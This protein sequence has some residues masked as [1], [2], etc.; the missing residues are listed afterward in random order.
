MR[1]SGA[2][3]D[4]SERGEVDGRPAR[5]FSLIELV[6]VL[7][8]IS[9]VAGMAVPMVAVTITRT[10]IDETRNE[11]RAMGP[12]IQSF[13]WDCRRFPP[14][15]DALQHNSAK[16]AGWRG[17]Y[18]NPQV[19]ARANVSHSLAQ[20]A[21]NR[22]YVLTAGDGAAYAPTAATNVITIRSLGPDGIA[23]SDD[24]IVQSVD[25]VFLRRK[26]TIDELNILNGAIQAYNAQ[27]IATAPLP[28]NMA[29]LFEALYVAGLLPRPP[30]K[31]KNKQAEDPLRA[32]AWGSAYRASPADAMPVIR[33]ES[34]NVSGV[35][36][37]G[38]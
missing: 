34:P 31:N 8:I 36:P 11:L 18:L 38:G 21:W 23:N 30:M 6:I 33:V 16:V 25:V 35:P 27:F 37:A 26:E 29:Q 3:S 12:A 17:P 19:S 28:I 20:D 1:A 22:P 14:T 13:W 2:A 9:V 15:L 5:G 4:R 7:A 24:D 32:D 10:R